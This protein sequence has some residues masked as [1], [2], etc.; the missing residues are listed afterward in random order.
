[1]AKKQI[2]ID[3]VTHDLGAEAQNVDYTNEDMEGVTNAE[4]A[5]DALNERINNINNPTEQ[6]VAE[7]SEEAATLSGKYVSVQG[8]EG[9]NANCKCTPF[10]STPEGVKM[11]VKTDYAFTGTFCMVFYRAQTNDV[12]GVIKVVSTGGPYSDWTEIPL[13]DNLRYIRWTMSNNSSKH[14]AIK[15]V[16]LPAIENVVKLKVAAWNVAGWDE[17]RSQMTIAE[18]RKAFREVFDSVDADIICMSEY[19]RLFDLNDNNSIAENEILCNYPFRKIG[20]GGSYTYNVIVSK[21]PIVNVREYM[22]QSQTNGVTEGGMKR[23]YKEATIRIGDKE[24]KVVSSHFDFQNEQYETEYQQSQH[25]EGQFQEIVSRYA[26][27][28]YVIIGA[29]FNVHK[30]DKNGVHK[31]IGPGES[32]PDEVYISSQGD[33]NYGKDG[34]LNYQYFIDAGYTLLNFDYLT[35]V[36]PKDGGTTVGA[37][38]ADNIVVKGFAMGAREYVPGTYGLSDHPMVACELVML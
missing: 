29:D 12:T 31:Y 1:M 36:N 6:V 37:H 13:P 17:P 32:D 34:Y 9:D 35:L 7:Y 33:E 15:F 5:L 8:T 2:I 25:Y 16:S 19:R 10:I 24:I 18:M 22:F 20:T 28:P 21:L 23:Y 30:W 26:N 3:G 4:G 14:I 11:L 27:E 38:T